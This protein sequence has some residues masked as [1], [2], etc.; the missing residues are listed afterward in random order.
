[1]SQQQRTLEDYLLL[2]QLVYNLGA[3]NWDTIA[4]KLREWSKERGKI[5]NM[6]PDVSRTRR[7]GFYA[8]YL[9]P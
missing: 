9:C 8:A 7:K 6:N 2:C 5:I 3:I 4:Y 1:M